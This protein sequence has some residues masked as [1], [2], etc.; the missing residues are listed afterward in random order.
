MNEPTCLLQD[1]W[2]ARCH[3]SV[4]NAT[5]LHLS[6]KQLKGELQAIRYLDRRLSAMHGIAVFQ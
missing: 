2:L 4:R 5:S 3:T 6:G 1:S